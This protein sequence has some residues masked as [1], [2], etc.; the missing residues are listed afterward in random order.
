MFIRAVT[1][2]RI[3]C[4]NKSAEVK[5]KAIL[6]AVAVSG[7]LLFLSAVPCNPE[8]PAKPPLPASE[9]LRLG[10]RMYRE[11]I[12]PSGEKMQAFVN[13]DVPVG[14]AF[15][16]V[17]CHLRGG[18]GS[19][20]GGVYTPPTNGRNL[21]RPQRAFYQGVEVSGGP[22]RRPAYTDESLADSIRGGIESSGRIMHDAM[23]RYK[24]T[25]DEMAILIFYLKALSSDFSPGV[26]DRSIRFATVITD[27]VSAEE[28]E[29]MLSPLEDYILYRNKSA[30]AYGITTGRSR[31]GETMLGSRD[32]KYLDIALSRWVVKGPPG[33]WRAQLEDYYKRE[34]VFALIGGI[35]K[36]E[37]KPIHEFSE[38]NR[39]PC[40]FPITD[41]PYI[42]DTDWYTMYVSRGYQQEGEGAA[43]YINGSP[44]LLKDRPVVEIVRESRE[45]R[46]LSEG[47]HRAW[48]EAGREMPLRFSLKEGEEL[49]A[50]FLIR[51]AEKEKPGVIL[52][53]DGPSALPAVVKFRGKD[54]QIPVFVASGYLGRDVWTLDETIRDMTYI[55]YPYVLPQ[56]E[57][58]RR[59]EIPFLNSRNLKG[60]AQRIFNRTYPVIPVLAQAFMDMRGNYYRDTF[61]DV[62][63][64]MADRWVPMYERLSFGPGQ[65]YASKGCYIVQ[66]SKGPVPQ[67]IPKSEWVV[68]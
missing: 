52:I 45:G 33:T 16:C 43:K 2:A 55:T 57:A 21:Y 68:H 25:D 26:S 50:G 11:G 1:V 41:F 19:K 62:V 3:G 51:L 46:A 56:D 60:D 47:F 4:L 67:L 54:D 38:E 48:K 20:E 9:M 44:D 7:L 37:W 58:K 15:T 65:R 22:P 29:A 64:M 39:I 61:L 24:L 32:T 10:E 8:V 36:G 49:T 30:K 59:L 12:L 42:S 23:P 53:W 5:M 27:D 18:L 35:T 28:K 17:S 34:P 31:M 14:G 66:L 63:S 40:L 13:D 6:L